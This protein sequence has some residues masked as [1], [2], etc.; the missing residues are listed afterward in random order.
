MSTTNPDD[1]LGQWLKFHGL[2]NKARTKATVSL[3]A[4]PAD[5]PL[6]SAGDGPA[7][8]V[9]GTSDVAAVAFEFATVVSVTDSGDRGL[10][11]RACHIAHFASQADQH[12]HFKS[13][14]HR[15]NLKRSLSGLPPLADLAAG[16]A[17]AGADA[18]SGRGGGKGSGDDDQED[19]DE[20]DENEEEEA[21]DDVLA[22]ADDY[23]AGTA[24]ATAADADTAPSA[25]GTSAVSA[26]GTVTKVLTKSDG[27]LYLFAPAAAPAWEMALSV[28]AVHR[29][30]GPGVDASLWPALGRALSGARERPGNMWG[31][32][33]LSSGRFAGAVFDGPTANVLA[34]RSFRRYT[35]RAKA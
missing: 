27:P 9:G 33:M 6:P 18:G 11:C 14:L 13:E 21:E 17:E 22:S 24:A 29:P 32:L 30:V 34:H 31:V 5:L 15:V 12:T 2:W 23:L 10:T 26:Q 19:D 4:L 28:V 20:D 7:T 8:A 16:G 25:R 3:F 1:V 35:V